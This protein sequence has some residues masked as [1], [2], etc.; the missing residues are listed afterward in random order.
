SLDR[1]PDEVMELGRRTVDRNVCDALT[2]G[3]DRL[4]SGELAPL[5]A[6]VRRDPAN[7]FRNRDEMLAFARS[8]VDRAMAAVPR[9]FQRLP[10]LPLH[11]E[12]Y[13]DEF[14]PEVSDSYWPPSGA[15]N[16]GTYRINMLRFA[17]RTR[18]EEATTSF[19]EAY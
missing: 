12:P 4:G 17:E 9:F 2:I 11:V 8:A 6:K 18:S 13:P 16:E 3:K 19:H 5:V 1:S 7:H 15:K 14:G 10:A